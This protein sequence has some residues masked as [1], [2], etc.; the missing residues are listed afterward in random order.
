MINTRMKWVICHSCELVVPHEYL[1]THLGKHKIYCSHDG[2]Y[3]IVSGRGLKSLDSITEFKEANWV[4]DIPV[5]GIP[6]NER[7]HR[8][9]K[10]QYYSPWRT[11]TEHFRLWHKGHD[12]KENTREEL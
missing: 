4:L 1:R 11:M 7:G 3:S 8:C 5:A 2:I 12:V 10:C 6:V 9:L